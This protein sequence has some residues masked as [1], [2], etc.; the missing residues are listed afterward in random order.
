MAI[1][2]DLST[3]A[4]ATT[5]DGLSFYRCA[6]DKTMVCQLNAE[7]KSGTYCE[8]TCVGSS[9]SSAMISLSPN[10]KGTTFHT[11][12]S[13]AYYAYN[14]DLYPGAIPYGSSWGVNDIV[15]ISMLGAKI[16]FWKNGVAQPEIAAPVSGYR[17]PSVLS[18][19]E[20]SVTYA[21][22]FIV[23]ASD[24]QYLPNGY[25]AIGEEGPQQSHV[26]TPII[27]ATMPA[28]LSSGFSSGVLG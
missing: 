15:G 21:G 18:S 8:L 2:I 27:L 28:T 26:P 11:A 9:E 4:N 24:M 3:K 17:F 25:A 1:A 14:G 6:A 19:T 12:G 5:V 13:A 23:Y 7:L 22:R 16:R 20:G 10:I